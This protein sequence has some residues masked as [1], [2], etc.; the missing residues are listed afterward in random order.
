MGRIEVVMKEPPFEP[1]TAQYYAH[2]LES[3]IAFYVR[4]ER[5]LPTL[6]RQPP[7]FCEG[8]LSLTCAPP[9]VGPALN[10]PDIRTE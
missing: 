1:D 3:T 8:L 7:N 9:R 5:L 2:P 6:S 10:P 4:R